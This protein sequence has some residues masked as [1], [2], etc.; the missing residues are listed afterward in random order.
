[1]GRRGVPRLGRRKLSLG[2]KTGTVEKRKGIGHLGRG[3][4]GS[5][6]CRGPLS[7][8]KKKENLKGLLFFL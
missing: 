1:V 7:G 6:L 3:V 5:E 2:T 4:L 8:K